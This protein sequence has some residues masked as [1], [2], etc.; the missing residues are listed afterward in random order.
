VGLQPTSN[1]GELVAPR[2]DGRRVLRDRHRSVRP[3][4]GRAAASANAILDDAWSSRRRVEECRRDRESAVRRFTCSVSVQPADAMS[5][6]ALDRAL[7]ATTRNALRMHCVRC[8]GCAVRHRRE[9]SPYA[10]RNLA[11]TPT[12]R[13]L[14]PSVHAT[15]IP[16]SRKGHARAAHRRRQCPQAR[17]TAGSKRSEEH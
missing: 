13:G 1:C 7:R 11:S 12:S 3:R 14:L 9:T 6:G 2:S 15:T 5:W 16:P 10:S 8:G 17:P 4:L